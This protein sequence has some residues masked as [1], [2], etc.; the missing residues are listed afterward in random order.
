MS[1]SLAR[2]ASRSGYVSS[3]K[4]FEASFGVGSRF[5]VTWT[6]IASKSRH[7]SMNYR[8]RNFLRACLVLLGRRSRP[9]AAPRYAGNQKLSHTER[10]VP[11]AFQYLT[12]SFLHYNSHLGGCI[13]YCILLVPTCI[14]F[15]RGYAWK[16]ARWSGRQMQ[17]ATRI[18]RD[19]VNMELSFKAKHT[20]AIQTIS[21]Q[22][23]PTFVP[24]QLLDKFRLRQQLPV[25]TTIDSTS[26]AK[27]GTGKPRD[28]ESR[29]SHW[30]S[31]TSLMV[32]YQLR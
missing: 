15:R 7:R 26:V 8:R 21:P 13:Q 28:T 22:F 24:L 18:P 5:G 30:Q 31:M 11:C 25:T 14:T 1:L 10:H 2:F 19:P 4:C 9:Q 3:H 16:A 27:A 29:G 12:E 23:C 17:E 32:P 6:P 20:W